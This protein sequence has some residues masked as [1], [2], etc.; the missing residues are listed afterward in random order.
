MER[1]PLD[2]DEFEFDTEKM[3]A[4]ALGHH[5]AGYLAGEPTEAVD[6][7]RYAFGV[8]ATAL[9]EK[10][11]VFDSSSLK[12]ASKT[13]NASYVPRRFGEC[14]VSRLVN[15]DACPRPAAGACIATQFGELGEAQRLGL[16][17]G[18]GYSVLDCREVAGDR[19]LLKLRNPWSHM[20]GGW[21]GEFGKASPV[22]QDRALREATGFEPG[23][24]A[25]APPGTDLAALTDGQKLCRKLGAPLQV[26]PCHHC[27]ETTAASTATG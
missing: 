22:W 14:R 4:K 18:H 9:Q 24:A 27:H 16:A 12:M 2:P 21:Q 10:I 19:R 6:S 5:R 26:R 3:W 8:F 13:P 11:G 15:R 25:P 17:I 1:S 20:K 23:P 7:L